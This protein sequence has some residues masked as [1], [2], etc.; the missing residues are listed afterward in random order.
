MQEL[1]KC[2]VARGAE[3][4]NARDERYVNFMLVGFGGK[5]VIDKIEKCKHHHPPFEK[6][7]KS[8]IFACKRKSMHS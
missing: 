6:K 8:N 1:N 5:L 2:E 4:R 7:M 3:S